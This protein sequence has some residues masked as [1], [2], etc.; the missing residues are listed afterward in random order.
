MSDAI[1]AK[2]IHRRGLSAPLDRFNAF[3]DGVFAIAVTLL[4]LE[5]PIP[6]ADAPILK[7]IAEEWA[8]FLGY[9]ISFAFIG[10]VWI[11]HSRLTQVMKASDTAAYGTNLLMLLF[12]GMLPFAT[13]VMVTHLGQPDVKVAVVIYGLVVLLASVTLSLLMIYVASEPKLLVDDV[14]DD[15][16]RVITRQRWVSIGVN[17]FGILLALFAPLVAVGLYL[18][19]TLLL[20]LGPLMGLRRQ[21]V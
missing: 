14:A 16:L 21:R 11:A 13:S 19:Q 6:P 8:A 3:S 20:L 7:S 2:T 1:E 18:V 15:F 4:V 5:L 10:G 17:A 9:F 12:V